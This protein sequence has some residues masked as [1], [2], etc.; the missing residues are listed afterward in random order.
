MWVDEGTA[1]VTSNNT[2][3][4]GKASG[5]NVAVLQSMSKYQTTT[6]VY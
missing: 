2:R 4:A 3:P 6:E 5:E 1:V